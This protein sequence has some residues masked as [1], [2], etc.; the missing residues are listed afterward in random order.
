MAIPKTNTRSKS[1]VW[2]IFVAGAVLS[3]GAYGALLH[4]GQSQ[5]GNPLKALLCVGIAYFL[6]GVI[7]PVATLSAQGS[8]SNFNTTGLMTATI[9]GALGAAGAACII[10]AFRNG[11]LPVY[12]MPLVFGGAPIVN[13]ML[14]MALHP[15]KSA[16]NPMLYIGF[17]L[18]SIG[19]AMVLY[20]RPTA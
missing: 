8:L 14:T 1:M 9:A 11:G 19:A 17:L 18:A 5:L 15:P 2:V 7:V 12:V 16:V 6:I 20:F 4:Q 10:W 3:W 13:V